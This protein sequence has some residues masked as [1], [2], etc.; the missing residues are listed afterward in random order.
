M[1][2]WLICPRGKSTNSKIPASLLPSKPAREQ[3]RA[4]HFPWQQPGQWVIFRP[5]GTKNGC[6]ELS[7]EMEWV[8]VCVSTCMYILGTS[9]QNPHEAHNPPPRP[10]L[11]TNSPRG[12]FRSLWSAHARFAQPAVWVLS[13]LASKDP[14]RGRTWKRETQWVWTRKLRVHT[15]AREPRN[16]QYILKYHLKGK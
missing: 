13:R 16:R 11:P 7:S 8:L 6:L 9:Q 2:P 15:L 4:S 14:H 5:T 12:L 1:Q 10:Q 3:E